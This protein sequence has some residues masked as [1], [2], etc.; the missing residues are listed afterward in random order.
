MA[1]P[2][3]TM[4]TCPECGAS[5]DVTVADTSVGPRG[6]VSDTPIYTLLRHKNWPQT[7]RDGEAWISCAACGAAEFMTV[8]DLGRP[9][10]SARRSR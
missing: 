4:I 6:P 1:I 2:I 9:G 10:S 3:R 5:Q 8:R 7:R